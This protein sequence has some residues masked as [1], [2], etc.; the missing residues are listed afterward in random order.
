MKKDAIRREFFRL[1]LSR[2]SYSQ[3]KKVLKEKYDYEVTI[4][5]PKGWR[6]RMESDNWDLRDKSTKPKTIR[7]KFSN[8]ERKEIISLRN[9]TGYSSHQIRIKL[10]EKGIV[11]SESFIKKIIKKGGLS[12][13]NKME[14]TRLKWVRFE[15]DNPNSMWQLDGTEM[16]DGDWVLPVEDD[17]SR[18]CVIIKKFKHMTTVKVIEVLEEAIAI[19]RKPREILT[20]NGSEFGGTSKESE[21]DK[22]CEKQNIIHI[23]SGVHKP[24][25]V[26]KVSAIQQT[27]KRE[28]SYCNND[29]EAWRMR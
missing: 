1:R 29:L 3:C 28:L 7:Y 24:T 16:D 11:M 27:I 17:C 15:R 20:D 4:R 2:N 13:G 18:Y 5:T 6:K 25:T 10:E 22:W 12:R 26:G 8:E 23:R 9:K 19:H 21:F 14:G